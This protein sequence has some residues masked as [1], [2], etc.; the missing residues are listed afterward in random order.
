[1]ADD[2]SECYTSSKLEVA[3]MAI[4]VDAVRG[5][6]D[7]GA[8]VNEKTS[9]TSSLP[10]CL[11]SRCDRN[12][13][14]EHIQMMK[15]LLDCGAKVNN[16]DFVYE[17]AMNH[18][19]LYVAVAIGCAESVKLLLSAGANANLHAYG[20][21]LF[22]NAVSVACKFPSYDIDILHVLLNTGVNVN[23]IE[24]WETPLRIA[25]AKHNMPIIQILLDHGADPRIG[26]NQSNPME[27]A[28]R[29][30]YQD[31]LNVFAHAINPT[32]A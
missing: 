6:L 10:L 12:G 26:L 19:P 2:L 17:N 3:C 15:L 13:N 22:H 28:K 24:F 23:Q 27:M 18:F 5:L 20:R 32:H 31:I 1:M 21:S 8:D 16:V 29:E 30:G 14:H 4:D 7:A 9:E 25:T 11:A